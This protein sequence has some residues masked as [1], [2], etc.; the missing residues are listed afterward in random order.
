MYIF[1]LRK[2]LLQCT[3]GR[4]NHISGKNLNFKLVYFEYI[5]THSGVEDGA[6][7]KHKLVFVK[8]RNMR[9]VILYSPKDV[10]QLPCN[11]WI[12]E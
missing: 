8:K 1:Q 2:Y 4:I 11:C 7:L 3:M 12:V 6:K 10:K 5:I 9:T